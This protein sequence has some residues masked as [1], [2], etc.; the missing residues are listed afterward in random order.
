MCKK[1]F[2]II[3][4]MI[5]LLAAP[6]SQ[7]WAQSDGDYYDLKAKIVELEKQLSS[8]NGLVKDLTY[9]VQEN[10]ALSSIV[11]ELSF[12]LKK[13]EGDLHSLSNLQDR[14][15]R[16]VMPQ[17]ISLQ[18]TVSSLGSS[19]SEKIKALGVRVYDAES[20][21][22][23]LSARI[24]SN[25]DRLR[26]LDGV[27]G[28][29]R[30]LNERLYKV[31][32]ALQSGASLDAVQSDAEAMAKLDERISSLSM[33]VSALKSQVS[34]LS[35]MGGRVDELNAQLTE[36]A[37]GL[38]SVQF[39][40]DSLRGRVSQVETAQA[41]FATFEELGELR[42]QVDSMA[43]ELTQTRNSANTNFLIGI[44]GVLAGIGAMGLVLL[45]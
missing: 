18:S 19:L 5:L 32:K 22:Q 2:P 39:T 3:V 34:D 11:K 24:K 38:S 7:A 8:V 36:V 13:S 12:Q 26:E 41:D 42:S 40:V 31:E 45:G 37:D 14:I 16:D 20:S 28:K 30:E 43:E 17:I 25:E 23:Q 1:A 15:E 4:A 33:S 10:Q 44:I 29:V 21:I 9:Q 35:G 27:D 6:A